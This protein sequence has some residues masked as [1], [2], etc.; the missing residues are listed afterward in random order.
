LFASDVLGMTWLWTDEGLYLGRLLN[1]AEPGRIW[2]EYAVHAEVQGA[3]SLVTNAA[4][5]KL[6]M[7]VN[8]TGA[9]VYEVSLPRIQNLQ[10]SPIA[11]TAEA[12]AAA[13]PWDPDESPPDAGTA[14]TSQ[15]TADQFRLSWPLRSAA[16]TLQAAPAV[17]GAWST[18]TTSRVTNG[19]TVTVTLP[20]ANARRF[21]R[22]SE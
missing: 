6:Y 22:L 4:T 8:D 18:V 14:L 15:L 19:E 7:V 12:A 11:L 13:V 5:G 10:S 1:D 21:F 17:T 9:H 2:D 16:M 3:V 20:A